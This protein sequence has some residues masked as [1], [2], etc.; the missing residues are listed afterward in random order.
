IAFQT[1]YLKTHYPVEFIAAL[2]TSELNNSDA[3]VKYITECR[4]HHIEVLPPDINESGLEFTVKD[5][6]IR[7][8]LV[9]VKNVGE[10]AIESI[11]G[12]REGNA[13]EPGGDFSS[14]FDFCERVDLRKVNKRVLEG[15]IKCGALDTTGAKR[16]RMTAALEDALEYGQRVQKEQSDPQMGLFDMG[17]GKGAPINQPQLPNIQEWDDRLRLANEKESLGFYVS[18]H[19]LGRFESA[20]DKFANADTESIHELADGAAVRLGGLVAAIKVIRTK[21]GDLMAFV[22]L[23]DLHGG[24]EVVVFS[25]TYAQAADLLV[26][27]NAVFIQGQIQKDENTVKIIAD[28]VVTM[29]QAEETWT[30]T[31]HIKLDINKTDRDLLIELREV[32]ENHTGGCQA[33]ICLADSDRSEVLIQLAGSLRLQAGQDL[34]QDIKR[35][36]GYDAVDTICAVAKTPVNGNGRERYRKG[37]NGNAR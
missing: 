25:S 20:I 10:G 16:S 28:Q 4:K 11:I 5:G 7:F 35:L 1:A 13:G 19:P 29:D 26:E 14:L 21:K 36:V 9:G 2:L 31:V 22:T 12:V 27:D 32:L 8:G 30:A 17:G 6:K 23:E 33:F 18:G 24:V 34:R 15:L 3:V 37:R